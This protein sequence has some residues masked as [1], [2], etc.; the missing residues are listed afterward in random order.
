MGILFAIAH[1]DDEPNAQTRDALLGV[2]QLGG[3]DYQWW[4]ENDKRR[5]ARAKPTHVEAAYTVLGCKSTDP[6]ETVRDRY[7][8]LVKDF[9]PDTVISKGLPADFVRFA[10]ERFKQIQAAYET[11]TEARMAGKA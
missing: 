4:T 8:K 9:H 7:R 5:K 11:V 2:C 3:F 6:A 1:A 10:E